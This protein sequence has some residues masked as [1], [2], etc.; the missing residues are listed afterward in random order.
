MKTHIET[1]TETGQSSGGSGV[2]RRRRR[3]G[4]EVNTITK[5]GFPEATGA[6]GCGVRA[7][8]ALRRRGHGERRPTKEATWRG[9]A[10]VRL[11]SN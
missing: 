8:A 5:M 4:G 6:R 1:E 9:G 7:R 10:R 3:S 11:K 2:A